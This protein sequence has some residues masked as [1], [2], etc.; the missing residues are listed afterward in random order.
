VERGAARAR[1]A[2]PPSGWEENERESGPQCPPS[3]H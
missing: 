3:V 1:P 2:G